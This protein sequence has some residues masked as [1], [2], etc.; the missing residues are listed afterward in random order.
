MAIYDY[1]N[2]GQSIVP[3]PP[4]KLVQQPVPVT[5]QQHS[6]FDILGHPI[7]DQ[8]EYPTNDSALWLELFIIVSRTNMECVAI[9][10]FIR[11]TGALLIADNKCGYRII[12]IIG[13]A[14]WESQDQYNAERN[15][16]IPHMELISHAL[17]ELKYKFGNGLVGR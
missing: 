7:V 15:A 17:K 14:G 13:P 5:P 3:P 1:L 6:L 9:L 16:L 12:P 8:Y 4:P 10:Q 2:T 11:K